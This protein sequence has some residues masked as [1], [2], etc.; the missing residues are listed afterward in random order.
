MSKDKRAKNKYHEKAESPVKKPPKPKSLKAKKAK[1][2]PKGYT[3]EERKF[4]ENIEIPEYLKHAS[5]KRKWVYKT[6]QLSRYK[7]SLNTKVKPQL[8][9][10]I[11][12]NIGRYNRLFQILSS[13]EANIARRGLENLGIKFTKSGNI[14]M[15]GI[16]QNKKAMAFLSSDFATQYLKKAREKRKAEM[17]K[18]LEFSDETGLTPDEYD[19]I[20]SELRDRGE[21]W[22]HASE[23]GVF[24]TNTTDLHNVNLKNPKYLKAMNIPY[25][26]DKN[27]DIILTEAMP[28]TDIEGYNVTDI[29]KGK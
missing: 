11:K 25:T 3:A 27:G 28:E 4:L 21:L 1:T 15:K 14:S 23:S 19:T 10:I 26:T 8:K 13:S 20:L 9:P 7:H 29:I 17:Q 12:T 22:Y 2:D 18:M 6:G 5:K 16:S 24:Y